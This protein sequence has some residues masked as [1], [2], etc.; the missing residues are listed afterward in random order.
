MRRFILSSQFI[1]VSYDIAD[2]KRLRKVA[3]CLEDYG[4][5]VQ[6]SVFECYLTESQLNRLNTRLKKLIEPEE[7]KLRLY[8]LCE[9]DVARVIVDGKGE[10]SKN[11]DYHIV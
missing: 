1:I 8:I 6:Y 3:L 4:Q 9:K 10:I 11:K 2:E 7:D 5:R